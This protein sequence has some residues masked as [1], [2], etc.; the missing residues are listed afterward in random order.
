MNE[1]IEYDSRKTFVNFVGFPSSKISELPQESINAC[2]AMNSLIDSSQLTVCLDN[3]KLFESVSRLSAFKGFS[4]INSIMRQ[5]VSDFTSLLRLP[6]NHFSTYK[7]IETFFTP[8]QRLHFLMINSSYEIPTERD[9]FELM[10][11]TLDPVNIFYQNDLGNARSYA[12]I[13]L[14]RGS[15]E[16]RKEKSVFNSWFKSNKMMFVEWIK[17]NSVFHSIKT[18]NSHTSRSFS[19]IQNS[20]NIRNLFLRL[21]QEFVYITKEKAHIESYLKQG[22][23]EMELIECESNI[24]DLYCQYAPC[25]DACSSEGDSFG[26][27]EEEF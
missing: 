23:D 3:C 14:S 6:G 27:E 11:K 22:I 17:S 16:S 19:F 4:D 13:L 25:C 10:M 1:L 12:S 9:R 20:Q 15:D 5:Q 7:K 26:Y 18:P 8:F 2:L 21:S 24:T